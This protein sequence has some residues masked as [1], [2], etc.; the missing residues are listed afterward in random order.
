MSARD[1][2][3]SMIGDISFPELPS[4]ERQRQLLVVRDVRRAYSQCD[5]KSVLIPPPDRSKLTAGPRPYKTIT[6]AYFSYRILQHIY[7][8]YKDV[9]LCTPSPQQYNYDPDVL[10]RKDRALRIG[11]RTKSV[12]PISQ[13]PPEI[14]PGTYQ[15][16]VARVRYEPRSISLTDFRRRDKLEEKAMRA[17]PSPFYDTSYKLKFRAPKNICIGPHSTDV[18][19][20]L[21][22]ENGRK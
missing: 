2:E 1:I 15:P 9:Q 14:G 7:G 18:S 16:R 13:T 8:P 4:K 5:R 6:Q 19:F 22:G 21:Y 20:L 12:V 17:R 3:Q 11:E 10:T